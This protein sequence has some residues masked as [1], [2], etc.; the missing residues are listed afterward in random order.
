MIRMAAVDDEKHALER[1]AVIIS[2]VEGV[3]LCGLFDDGDDLLTFAASNPLEVVFLDIEMPGKTGLE[4]AEDLLAVNPDILVVFATAYSQYAVEAFDLNA[5]DYILKPISR[6]RLEKT[7]AR[8][9]RRRPAPTA[10]TMKTAEKRVY[11]QCFLSFEVLLNNQVVPLNSTKARELLAFLVSKS[12]ASASWEQ[13][14]EALWYGLDYEKAHNNLYATVYRLRKW[15]A[16]MGISR[17]LDCKRNSYRVVPGE[18]DCDWY[19]FEKAQTAEDHAKMKLLY[20]GTYMEE[21]GYEWAYPKQAELDI[22]MHNIKVN[23]LS[24]Q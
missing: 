9:S 15:L 17:I 18:F 1:F 8:V 6:E 4:L 12:G 21:N 3:E 11:I 2:Q 22:M 13:I 16:E 5:L 23:D 24:T 10:V 20:K 19:E 7:L 14:T